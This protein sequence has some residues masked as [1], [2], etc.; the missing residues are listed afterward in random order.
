ML[1]L[2]LQH[3]EPS[4]LPPNPEQKAVN[5]LVAQIRRVAASEP[6]VYG[7]DTRIR[8]AEVLTPKYSG[9]AKDLLHDAQAELSAV[10]AAAEQDR[11]RVRLIKALAPLDLEEAKRQT[12]S[13]HPAGLEDY[14]A[15]A[16]DQLFLFLADRPGEARQIISEG[17]ADGALR[18]VSAS[19]LLDQLKG[20]D[21]D[22]ATS[23][24]SEMLAALP[25]DSPA[26]GDILFLIHETSKITQLSRPLAFEAI[27][28]E[29]SAATSPSLR[30][31][32]QD[33]REMLLREIAALLDSI[34]LGVLRHY[35]DIHP[36]LILPP[37]KDS[38]PTD[39]KGE[40]DAVDLSGLSYSDALVRA[41]QLKTVEARAGALIEISR[42]EDLTPQQRDSVASEALSNVNKMPLTGDRLVGLAMISRDFA[43]RNEPAN[44][45]LAAQMLSETYAK[46]CD[47]PSMTC[48]HGN[49][50]FDCMQNV[51]DFAEYLNEFKVSPDSMS[52][53]NISLQARLLILKLHALLT[54]H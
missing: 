8:A 43:R 27:D 28:Q 47:C 19:R 25:E 29:V 15:Q 45:A 16:Y 20:R 41:R 50:D 36:E 9:L 38:K 48:K 44:A 17:L 22:A 49:E 31:Y 51:E 34:D 53:D 26:S 35:Q 2:F 54:A 6:A 37:P 39:Q 42:R 24:F 52:L 46:A 40:D 10:N 13:F 32:G 3:H 33:S 14:K 1:L 23:L 12:K 18:M 7:V 21:A 11:M 5:T 4:R 30:L